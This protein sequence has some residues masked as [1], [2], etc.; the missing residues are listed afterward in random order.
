[1]F[2]KVVVIDG[3]GHLLGRLASTI[4]KELLGGCV[5]C[6][7]SAILLHSITNAFVTRLIIHHRQHVVITRCEEVN[8]SGN[9]KCC[10][11]GFCE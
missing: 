4:A 6:V 5:Q 8:V 11:L 9:R 10:V 3:R 7:F 1:M 2:E